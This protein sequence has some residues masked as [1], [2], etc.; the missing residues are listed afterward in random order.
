MNAPSG[1]T[2]PDPKATNAA[3]ELTNAR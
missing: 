1:L 2:K 3:F